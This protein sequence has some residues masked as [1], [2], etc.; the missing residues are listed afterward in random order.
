MVQVPR[1]ASGL[2]CP[3]HRKDTSKV[4]HVCPLWTQVR[5]ADPQSGR[6]IDD[7]RC[8]MAWLPTLILDGSQ[9]TRQTGAS[10]DK[11]ATEVAKVATEVATFHNTMAT[12]NGIASTTVAM[13]TPTTGDKQ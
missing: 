10:A 12:L 6:E 11:V 5:G 3:F 9:Q 1:A 7:W 8:A 2:V 13:L 4:C